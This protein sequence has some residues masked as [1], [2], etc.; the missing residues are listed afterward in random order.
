MKIVRYPLFERER[1]QHVYLLK[2]K[3]QNTSLVVKG[4]LAYR[5]QRRTTCKIQYGRQGAPKWRMGSGKVSTPR[6]LGIRSNFR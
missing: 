1:P 6:F 2:K 5:L 4:A 3:V